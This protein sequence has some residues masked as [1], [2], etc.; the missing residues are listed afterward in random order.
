[1]EVSTFMYFITVI[2]IAFFIGFFLEIKELQIFCIYCI[3]IIIFR[4]ITMICC[5]EEILR[6]TSKKENQNNYII[7]K[8]AIISVSNIIK[9][10][11]FLTGII[12]PGSIYNVIMDDY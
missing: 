9:T 3:D 6:P 12:I 10:L 1:M 5:N 8:K 4:Y 7:N 2:I 11:Y